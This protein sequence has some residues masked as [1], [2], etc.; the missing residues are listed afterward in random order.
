MKKPKFSVVRRDE[1]KPNDLICFDADIDVRSAVVN[2]NT[3]AESPDNFCWYEPE[4]Y[5]YLPG[6]ELV[7]RRNRK[8]QF[9]T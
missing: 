9:L 8:D 5:P 7:I 6:T 2:L 3:G 4:A 1:C